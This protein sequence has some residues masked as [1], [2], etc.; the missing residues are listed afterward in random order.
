MAGDKGA[1]VP[2]VVT[3]YVKKPDQAGLKRM[4]EGFY[5]KRTARPSPAFIEATQRARTSNA[6][7][8]EGNQRMPG[9]SFEDYDRR[10][11]AAKVEQFASQNNN[12]AD[13]FKPST[14]NF[15]SRR[16]VRKMPSAPEPQAPQTEE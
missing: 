1:E 11:D 2:K 10:Q 13:S 8:T 5:A 15:Y 3:E 14:E 6:A 4:Q 9:E 12:M 7:R 16:N